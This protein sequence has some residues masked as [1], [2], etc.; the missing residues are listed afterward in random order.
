[1]VGC[2]DATAP[3]PGTFRARL[4]GA[5]LASLSGTSNAS[6]I[7]TEALPGWVFAIRMF[8]GQG[9][10]LRSISIQCPGQEPPAPG[11][12]AIDTVVNFS[13][14]DC[15]GGYGRLIS[16]LEGTTILE[17]ASASSGRVTINAS[18]TDQ[19]EGTFNFSGMLVVGL[20]SVGTVAASGTFSAVLVP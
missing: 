15:L 17:L 14:P 16:T 11:T 10:T 5:R 19:L 3:A 12:Y 18:S 6:A 7:T 1:M 2:S 9:D 20:D 8:D 13:E 4:T